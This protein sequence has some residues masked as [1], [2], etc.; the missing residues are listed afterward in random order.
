MVNVLIGKVK[1]FNHRCFVTCNMFETISSR[2]LGSF[3]IWYRYG[4]IRVLLVS[5]DYVWELRIWEILSSQDASWCNGML[6]GLHMWWLIVKFWY[7][8][9]LTRTVI[10]CRVVSWISN[11]CFI[12]TDLLIIRRTWPV[13]SVHLST[14]AC[15]WLD[16]AGS[17][18]WMA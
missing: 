1:I 2:I 16:T 18:H 13:K 12:G 5:S 11:C 15:W 8:W 7:I 6:F 9:R 4:Q 14:G 10:V 17:G 3:L